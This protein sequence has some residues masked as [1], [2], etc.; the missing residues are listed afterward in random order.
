LR[1]GELTVDAISSI[2]SNEKA[3]EILPLIDWLISAMDERVDDF[4]LHHLR[5]LP[6]NDAS[7]VVSL[8]DTADPW[9][10]RTKT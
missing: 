7:Y 4:V 1:S 2:V 8:D 5:G 9:L 3:H 10:M 6:P